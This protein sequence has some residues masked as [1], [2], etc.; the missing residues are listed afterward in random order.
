MAHNP[1]NSEVDQLAANAASQ[2]EQ[3]DH[4][5]AVQY[6]TLA[7]GASG[8]KVTQLVNLLAVLGHDTNTVI[9]GAEPVLDASVLADVSAARQ[10]LGVPYTQPVTDVGAGVLGALIDAPLWEAL[11]AAA[12][13]KLEPPAPAADGA[14]PAAS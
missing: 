6:T 11:Y 8:E 4:A 5:E 10:Q 7:Y 1:T 2:V 9:H 14:A 13:A 12:S 3:A